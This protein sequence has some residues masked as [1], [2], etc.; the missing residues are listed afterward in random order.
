MMTQ[1]MPLDGAY[2]LKTFTMEGHCRDNDCYHKCFKLL[3][4]ERVCLRVLRVSVSIVLS[5]IPISI[6]HGRDISQYITIWNSP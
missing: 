6:S 1:R 5:S 4:S 3:F 2:R